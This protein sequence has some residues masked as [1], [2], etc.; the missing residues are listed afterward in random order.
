MKWHFLGLF[1]YNPQKHICEKVLLSNPQNFPL[2]IN[3][4]YMV[5]GKYGADIHPCVSETSPWPSRLVWAYD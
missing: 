5:D 2:E 1:S 4:L 3:P